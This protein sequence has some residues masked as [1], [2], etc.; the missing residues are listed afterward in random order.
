MK[1]FITKNF[2][3]SP[4]VYDFGENVISEIKGNF[5]ALEETA[6][7]NQL[8]VLKA[9]QDNKVS[10]VHFNSTTGYGYDDAGREAIDKIYAQV[11]G[12]ED[13]LVRHNIINGTHAISLCLFAVLRPGDTLVAATG[14][15]YDTLEE[16]IGITGSGN[17][18]LKEFGINYKQV[19]LI[20]GMVN[21]NKIMSTVDKNTKAV[22]IQKSKGYSFRPSLTCEEIGKI[23]K[24]VKEINP[25]TICV[26]D[27]CYGEFAERIEPAQMGADLV[28]GSLI[29]N[30]GGGIAETGGYIAGRAD[31]VE[32]ASYKLN[33]VGLGKHVGATLGMNKQI[34]QGFFMA[35]KTVCESIKTAVFCGA[36]YQKLG[37]EVSPKK[38]DYRSDIIQAIR[39]GTEEGIIKFCQGIQKGAPV[40]SFVTPYPWDMP[41]YSHRVIMAAGAFTQG[42]SIELSA[43]GPITLPY[44]AYMQGGLTFESAYLGVLRSVQEMKNA[45]LITV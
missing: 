31:L 34:L 38:D 26:V 40:D 13:S 6:K 30:P 19:D 18:S 28:A 37:F 35:P 44:I 15:P 12:A 11:F 20:D 43:D 41:G 14:K 42:A 2:D 16:V 3:I 9:F 1:D 21:Y 25:D 8:K 29:K 45:G 5:A 17:G 23:I 22:I 36:A 33:S 10:D 39:F 24:T 7:Y 4:G 27:N 32:L